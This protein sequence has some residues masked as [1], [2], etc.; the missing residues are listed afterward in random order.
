PR[1]VLPLG[2]RIRHRIVESKEPLLHS[3]ECC[4]S[5]KTFCPAKDRPSFVCRSIVCVMLGNCAA[6]LHYQHR[7]AMPALG[8]FCSTLAIRHMDFRKCGLRDE[9]KRE[10]ETVWVAYAS[11]VLASASWRSRTCLWRPPNHLVLL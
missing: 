7:T 10:C 4:D 1:I 8:V 11:R 2:D 6:I 5:P 3:G 9:N